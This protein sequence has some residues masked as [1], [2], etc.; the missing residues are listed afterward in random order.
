MMPTLYLHKQEVR[1]DEVRLKDNEALIPVAHFQK[2]GQ[3]FHPCVTHAFISYPT[4]SL[5][6]LDTPQC[7]WSAFLVEDL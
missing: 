7:I 4:L 3:T 2:V 6:A 1:R 5:S